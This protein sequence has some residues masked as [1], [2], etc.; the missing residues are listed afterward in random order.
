[1]VELEPQRGASI[2]GPLRVEYTLDAELTRQV[3]RVLRQGR[4]KLGH[5]ILLEPDTGR[6]LTYASTDIETFPPT[7]AYPARG[8]AGEP[9]LTQPIDL[10]HGWIPRASRQR[11]RS[12]RPR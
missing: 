10:G 7:R 1:M 8:V 9:D 11:R 4:V 5:V 2:S 6:I 3:F 12:A